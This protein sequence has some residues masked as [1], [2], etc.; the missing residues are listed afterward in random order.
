MKATIVSTAALV[1]MSLALMCLAGLAQADDS[2][3][4][5]PPGSPDARLQRLMTRFHQADVNGD[6]RLTAEE[7]RQGMPRVYEHFADI[8]TDHKG[9]ITLRQ[10]TAYLQA[11]AEQRRHGAPGS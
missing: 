4:A 1:L 6:G 3:A 5:S 8:D 9:Y 10:I 2:D 11:H 7:A